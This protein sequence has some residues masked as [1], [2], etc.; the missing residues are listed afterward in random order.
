LSDGL[1]SASPM[2]TVPATETRLE[3]YRDADQWPIDESLAAMLDSQMSAYYAVR[4]AMAD[5]KR[6]VEQALARLSAG[7]GRIVYAG[8]GASIRLAV[9]DGVELHPTF[10]WSI[11]RLRYCI[12]GGPKALTISVEGGEDDIDEARRQVDE[13]RLT[14]A[15]IVVS[16]SASGGTPFTCACQARARQAGALTIAIAGNPGSRLLRDADCGIVLACGPE[17]LAGSTRMAAGTAQK[18]ALNLFST[19]LMMGLGHVHDGL[20]VDVVAT[21]AKLK[22]RAVEI[23]RTVAKVGEEPASAALQSA[24]GNIKL[25]VLMLDGLSPEDAER[26]LVAANYRLR[27]ARPQ[28]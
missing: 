14:P 16:V 25:A 24:G 12:A 6:A 19:Q 1:L 9:Q 7:D 2:N 3:R 4:S 5:L 22:R 13:L 20:M 18:I 28:G 27:D 10:G 11:D 8:A 15:D 21:N 17:F 23:V 26:R